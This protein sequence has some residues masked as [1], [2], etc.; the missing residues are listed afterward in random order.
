[1]KFVKLIILV[2]VLLY[3]CQR[4]EVPADSSQNCNLVKEVSHGDSSM[5][6]YDSQN[7][8]VYN[9]HANSPDDDVRYT[10]GTNS[11]TM[12]AVDTVTKY[13]KQLFTYDA[14]KNIIQAK[15]FHYFRSPMYSQIRRMGLTNNK[16]TSDSL[17][18][19]TLHLIEVATYTWNGDNMVKYVSPD[20]TVE[21]QYDLSKTSSAGDFV[22]EN[23][24]NDSDVW[25]YSPV[26]N[27]ITGYKITY[28]YGSVYTL[29]ANYVFD[30]NGR[31]TS[32]TTTDSDS[33]T[34]TTY[35]SYQCQ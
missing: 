1:M 6:T 7:R 28:R 30:S 22:W 26:K 23:L 11:M 27:L 3:S 8:V 33:D 10:Y 21:F 13:S 24:M 17:F 32:V 18:D 31:I 29:A 9:H 35:Y 5:Y 15:Y 2:S 25:F 20:M 4:E 34:V 14:N 19:S 16:V 12:E